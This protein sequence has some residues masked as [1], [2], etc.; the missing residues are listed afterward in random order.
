MSRDEATLSRLLQTLADGDY[1]SGD[2]LGQLLGVSRAAIWKQLQKLNEL[3]VELESVRGKGYCLEGGLELLDRERLWSSL[4][5]PVQ[6]RLSELDVMSVADSTNSRAMQKAA[7]GQGG[8]VCLAEQQTAGRGRRGRTWISPFGRNLY[9]SL[10]WG[11]EGGAAQL[12][13]L[14]LA[15]GVAMCQVLESQGLHSVGL[16]WP[17]DLLWQK[18]K[19]AGVLLEMTGDPAG[20]CHV[21]VGVGLNLSMPGVSAREIEQPWVDLQTACSSEACPVPGRNALA[22][23]MI[24]ALVSLLSEY[25]QSGFSAWREQWLARDAFAGR[26]VV[27]SSGARTQEGIARGV[28][29]SGALVLDQDGEQLLCHGGELSMRAV[30]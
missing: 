14:S 22:A 5:V 29:I 15:V 28:D 18:R 4:S 23:K 19:L 16:K 27:V 21:V 20:A 24:N 9:L 12:E 3:G 10:S 6:S 26:R 11:F 2:E 25:H 17:N 8:Y 7:L 13:G 1:H 30:S